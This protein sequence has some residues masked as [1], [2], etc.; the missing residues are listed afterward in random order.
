MRLELCNKIFFNEIALKVWDFCCFLEQTFN[1]YAG[2]LSFDKIKFV[3]FQSACV[4]ILFYKFIL[5]IVLHS[6]LLK[7][8]HLSSR[9]ECLYMTGDVYQNRNWSFCCFVLAWLLAWMSDF[10]FQS[11]FKNSE[12]PWKAAITAVR[13]RN[14]GTSPLS[15]AVFLGTCQPQSRK[16]VCYGSKTHP[17]RCQV[18]VFIMNI[19]K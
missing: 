18:V 11:Y 10:C 3:L 15:Q 17:R 7:N 5:C 12:G 2:K 19:G 9:V 14:Q 16:R 8:L 4:F 13:Q 6:C 1:L